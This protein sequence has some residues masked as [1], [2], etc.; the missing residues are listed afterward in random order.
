MAKDS[1]VPSFDLFGLPAFHIG[2]TG[3]P[4]DPAFDDGYDS[5]ELSFVHVLGDKYLNY[6]RVRFDDRD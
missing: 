5:T 3:S 4:L 6:K 2:G 1:P